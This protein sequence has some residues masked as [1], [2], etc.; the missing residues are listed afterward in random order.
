MQHKPNSLQK[1]H[2]DVLEEQEQIAVLS[3]QVEEKQ[4]EL[5]VTR[6]EMVRLE[7]QIERL[8]DLTAN[9]K[10]IRRELESIKSSLFVKLYL[11]TIWPA[12]NKV[13]PYWLRRLTKATILKLKAPFQSIPADVKGQF[14][15]SI[16]TDL[17]EPLIVGKG[18]VLYLTGLCY[19]TASKLQQLSVVVDDKPYLV[20]NYSM[21]A[22]EEDSS[23]SEVILQSNGKNI[24]SKFWATIPLHSINKPHQASLSL[25][26]VLDSK[27]KIVVSIG[28]LTLLPCKEKQIGDVK[29][30]DFR[31][32]SK[33]LV[34]IC[35]TT[36]NPPLDLFTE[37]IETIIKQT[38]KNFI[39]II[40]DDCSDDNIY[41]EIQRIA[42]QDNRFRVYRNTSRLNFYH[43]FEQCLT[44]VPE[45]ADFVALADQDDHWYPDKLASCLAAFQEETT[46]VY[47]DMDIVKRDGKLISHTYWTTRKNNYTDLE[48]LLFANT[49]T[50]AASVFRSNLLTEILPF[51]KQIHDSYHDHWIG[52]V[53]LTRGNINYIDKPLYAYRQHSSNVVGHY[54]F[55]AHQLLPKLSTI[56]HWLRSPLRYEAE[57]SLYLQHQYHLY[58]GFL[59]RIIVIAKIL[60]LRTKNVSPKK[61]YILNNFAKLEHSLSFLILQGIKYKLFRRPTLGTELDALRAVLGVRILKL[62]YQC[63]QIRLNQEIASQ[64]ATTAVLDLQHL[65]VSYKS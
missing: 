56:S 21:A 8:K 5:E 65:F 34:A 12:L 17:S 41:K 16:E 1:N 44:L 28:K 61:A 25:H 55:P 48:S 60:A 46:L 59:M 35:M 32:I 31:S 43:N 58:F 45:N 33:P 18:N 11:R 24:T 53:A 9:H 50:G 64:L 10:Q 51:P 54:V 13:A 4:Y 6:A 36:Y 14:V 23:N 3:A 2:S 40:N 37:Q 62:Y 7:E 29:S 15:W 38:Y 26:A 57:I 47:S 63:K 22:P 27:E 42:L 52:C 30:G 49:I 20:G 39:C 19:H